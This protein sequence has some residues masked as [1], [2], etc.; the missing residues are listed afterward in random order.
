MANTASRNTQQKAG[1][2]FEA[3]PVEAAVIVYVGALAAINAAGNLVPASD[4]AALRVLGRCEGMPGPG[5]TGLDANNSAGAAGAISANVKQ[6][7]FKY[8]NY[9]T[10]PVVAADIGKTCYV[11]DDATVRHATGTNS[12]KAGIVMG[13]DDAGLSVWVDTE[14]APLI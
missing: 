3:I 1:E 5:L 6:G 7:V 9:A 2:F 10:D 4:T 11:F 8:D 13:L 14:A 12:I